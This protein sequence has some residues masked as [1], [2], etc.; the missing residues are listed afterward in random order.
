LVI[1]RRGCLR[2]F[3]QGAIVLGG[4]GLLSLVPDGGNPHIVRPPGAVDEVYFRVLCVRCGIC[5]EVCPT[6]TIVLTGFENGPA[7][8]NTP[9]I[10]P[11]ISPCEF[12]RG[13]C[14]QRMQCALHCPTG[15]LRQVEKERVKLGNDEPGHRLNLPQKQLG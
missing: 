6:G 9:K 2:L 3:G 1:T 15:A 10:E 8:A 4:F 12:Y 5:L 7:A 14:E 11:I 13:R